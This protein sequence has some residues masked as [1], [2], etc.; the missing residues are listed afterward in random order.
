MEKLAI[1]IRNFFR[2]IKIYSGLFCTW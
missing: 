2:K 1:Y